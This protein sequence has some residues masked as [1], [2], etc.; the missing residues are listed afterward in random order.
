MQLIVYF[1][2]Q[3]KEIRQ[4]QPKQLSI[5]W[6]QEEHTISPLKLLVKTKYLNQRQRSIEQFL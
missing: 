1:M 2:F 6:F 3:K 4:V 5:T